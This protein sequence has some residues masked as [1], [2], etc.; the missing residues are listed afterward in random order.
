MAKVMAKRALLPVVEPRA[1]VP[2]MWLFPSVVPRDLH[3]DFRP[4][5]I[6][7]PYHHSF[8]LTAIIMTFTQN[9]QVLHSF[10][11]ALRP[12]HCKTILP[13]LSYPF[14]PNLHIPWSGS[15]APLLFSKTTRPEM[16][17]ATS[18]PNGRIPMTPNI[19]FDT[20]LF[21]QAFHRIN[22][23]IWHHLSI[24]VRKL[25]DQAKTLWRRSLESRR[26]G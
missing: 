8:L 22:L 26:H 20:C 14:R 10:N 21:P 4:L 17:I 16:T 9:S 19:C 13:N 1:E 15:S 11:L 18:I 25:T 3:T 12:D 5:F 24:I 6:F 2:Q 23:L 7:T